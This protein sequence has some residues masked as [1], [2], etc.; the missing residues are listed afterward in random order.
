MG[1]CRSQPFRL[2][3]EMHIHGS[4]RRRNVRA[5]AKRTAMGSQDQFVFDREGERETVCNTH[6]KRA[7]FW[8]DDVAAAIPGDIPRQRIKRT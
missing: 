6:M 2:A 8:R 5:P 1:A 3:A 7:E 4:V